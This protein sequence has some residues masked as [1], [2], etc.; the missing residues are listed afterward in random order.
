MKIRISWLKMLFVA[1]LAL[2]AHGFLGD[3]EFS[4]HAGS[5]L[6]RLSVFAIVAAFLIGAIKISRRG[7]ESDGVS[8]ELSF[9]GTGDTDADEQ[10]E[11]TFTDLIASPAR[12]VDYPCVKATG[13]RIVYMYRTDGNAIALVAPR[14]LSGTDIPASRLIPAIFDSASEVDTGDV[15][16]AAEGEIYETEMGGRKVF[17]F[18]IADNSEYDTDKVIPNE[19]RKILE[20]TCQAA[21]L[22]FQD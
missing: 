17:Y 19:F 2:V 18:E 8:L 9:G 12:Y 15:I 14:H 3:G 6:L 16:N 11:I 7:E 22:Q 21:D 13:G 20:D 10:I 4:E 1:A 5:S